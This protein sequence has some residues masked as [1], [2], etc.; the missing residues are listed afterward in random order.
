MT[1]LLL[2][3]LLA[4]APHDVCVRGALVWQT[5]SA[6]RPLNWSEQRTMESCWFNPQFCGV[7]GCQ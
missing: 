6:E 4:Q 2:L 1:L 3:W 5:A 7:E